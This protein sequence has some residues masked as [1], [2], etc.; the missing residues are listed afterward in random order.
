MKQHELYWPIFKAD[1]DFEIAH[2]IILQSSF[3]CILDP[4]QNISRVHVVSRKRRPEKAADAW[5]TKPRL[6]GRSSARPATAVG[7]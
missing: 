6:P 1:E 7:A 2:S 4:C 5:V 3:I